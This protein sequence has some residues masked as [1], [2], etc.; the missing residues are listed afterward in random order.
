ME[1]D[2]EKAVNMKLILCMFEQL[3]SLKINFHKCEIFCF[4][5]ARDVQHKYREIIGC[6]SGTL[7]IRYMGIAIHH[8]TL[9]NAEWNPIESLFASKLGC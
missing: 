8:R 1:R 3:S 9:R 7:P 6:E 4:D 2:L 5:K